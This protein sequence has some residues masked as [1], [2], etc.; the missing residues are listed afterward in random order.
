M[1]Q[2][3]RTDL[4]ME[5]PA[6]STQNLKGI[7]QNVKKEEGMTITQI[8][9][10]S[11]E[12]A[13]ALSKPCGVYTTLETDSLKGFSKNFEGEIE[14]IANHL[15]EMLPQEGTVLVVGLGNADITPDAVGPKTVEGILATRH[16][17]GGIAESIG[18][19]SL[20][21]VAA[22]IPGVLGQTGIETAEI[23]QSLC[24]EIHPAAVIVID[25]LAARSLGRLGKTIQISD[26]GISPGSGVQ[27]QRKEISSKTLNL[28]VIAVGVPTVVDMATIV[29]DLLEQPNSIPKEAETMM[30]APR[31]ID[32]MILQTAKLLSGGINRAL[33]PD[34]SMEEIITLTS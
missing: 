16:L 20:R 9:I 29:Y 26:A 31:E 23:I 22:A 33:Q 28:P 6:L 3:I 27:N 13:K 21:S 7:E 18:L 30:V 32:K 24:K 12:A 14:V 10:K 34:L 11:D 4:A 17:M 8:R 1:N 2:R 19:S 15:K 5:N 25:A